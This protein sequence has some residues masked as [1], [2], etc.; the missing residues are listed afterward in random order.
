MPNNKAM[1]KHWMGEVRLRWKDFKNK[2]TKKY[3][4]GA[5]KDKDPCQDY[6]YISSEDWREFVAS[7]Q[8]PQFLVK[9]LS[10]LIF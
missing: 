4:R 2:L 3:I 10:Y 6:D 9:F 7:R 1:Y 8:S 5:K